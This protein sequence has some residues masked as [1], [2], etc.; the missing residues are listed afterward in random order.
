MRNNNLIFLF[1]ALVWFCWGFLAL[2]LKS[3]EI[4]ETEISIKKG[5]AV[6]AQCVESRSIKG[7]KFRVIYSDHKVVDDYISLPLNF[8][9]NKTF[10]NK[11]NNN[12][13][14]IAY[15]E[16]RYLGF[17]IDGLEIRTV[18]ES[19]EK[20]N[21]KG[22]VLFFTLFMAFIISFSLFMYSRKS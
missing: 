16:N 18:E 14:K 6:G 9:C 12:P 13:V 1:I 3:Q 22:G 11:F 4:D 8:P 5:I 21:N 10:I 15:Y 19:I 2:F 7:V 20:V 17:S